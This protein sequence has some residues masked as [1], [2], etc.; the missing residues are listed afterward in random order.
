VRRTIMMCAMCLVASATEVA[1]QCDLPGRWSYPLLATYTASDGQ[2]AFVY[3]TAC[4]LDIDINGTIAIIGC[5]GLAE[6]GGDPVANLIASGLNG[7]VISNCSITHDVVIGFPDPA[8][9]QYRGQIAGTSGSGA[10]LCANFS[11][12]TF[13]LNKK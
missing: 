2:V 6:S 10:V 4:E 13:D 8:V 3:A 7:A 5:A 12:A 11:R 9:C 1:A